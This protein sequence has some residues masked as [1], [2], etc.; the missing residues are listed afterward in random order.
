MP[1]GVEANPGDS[2]S[3]HES[4]DDNDSLDVAQ[5]VRI[6]ERR[7][8]RAS[9]PPLRTGYMLD[10][11]Y[12]HQTDDEAELF[13][14]QTQP[15][16]FIFISDQTRLELIRSGLNWRIRYQHLHRLYS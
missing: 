12:V 15:M 11:Q 5:P 6:G 14:F 16:K 9:F 10:S 7:S 4:D 2:E 13:E 1:D 8:T 3:E